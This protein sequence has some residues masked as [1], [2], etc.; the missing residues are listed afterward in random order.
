MEGSTEE[1][2]EGSKEGSKEGSTEESK[3]G[4]TENIL[5]MLHLL[6]LDKQCLLLGFE[7]SHHQEE[8]DFLR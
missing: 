3:E 5:Y 6:F 1:S 8:K 2:T 7:K 4:N